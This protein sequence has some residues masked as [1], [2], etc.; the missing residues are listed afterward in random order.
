MPWTAQVAL[1]GE[2]EWS[3]VAD[4]TEEAVDAAVTIER[5]LGLPIASV[6]DPDGKVVATRDQIWR[7]V[8]VPG[9][10]LL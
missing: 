10:Q 8:L 2:Q 7:R 4:S 6:T 5:T 1:E 3:L 9:S